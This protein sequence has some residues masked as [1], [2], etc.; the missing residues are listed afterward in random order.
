MWVT[1]N[2]YGV[3]SGHV[4]MWELDHKESWGLKNWCFWI[5]VLEKTLASPLDCKE[6]QPV[7]PKGDRS[8]VFI[9]RTDAETDWSS[10]TLATWFEELTHRKRPWC[11]ERLKAGGEGDDRGLRWLDGITDSMDMSLS[12]LW[13]MG[14]TGKAGVLQYMGSQNWIQL[15]DWTTSNAKPMKAVEQWSSNRDWRWKDVSDWH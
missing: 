2:L 14:R 6:I 15:S 5:V 1:N 11:W 12:K 9:G 4:W 13:E 10:N 7:H 8:W 3:S